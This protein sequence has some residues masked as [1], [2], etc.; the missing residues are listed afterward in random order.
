MV[1]GIVQPKKDT[2][3][4]AGSLGYVANATATSTAQTEEQQAH[5]ESTVADFG[6]AFATN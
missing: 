2:E 4:T 1:E 5:Y 6:S 3:S